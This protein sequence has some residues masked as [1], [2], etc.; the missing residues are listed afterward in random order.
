MF[1][2]PS[3]T[4]LYIINAVFG[5]ILDRPIRFELLIWTV[6]CAR[7]PLLSL[8]WLELFFAGP[9]GACST[10]RHQDGWIARRSGHVRRG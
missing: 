9:I 6:G 8:H 3:W 10:L 4:A 7:L 5:A 2:C 1:E